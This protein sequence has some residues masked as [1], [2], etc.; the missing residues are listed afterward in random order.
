MHNEVLHFYAQRMNLNLSQIPPTK[1]PEATL[2][3]RH[4]LL[5]QSSLAL[6]DRSIQ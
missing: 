6:V 5:R 3:P 4:P 1:P 2:A